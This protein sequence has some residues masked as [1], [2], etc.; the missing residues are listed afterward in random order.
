MSLDDILNIDNFDK[1]VVKLSSFDWGVCRYVYDNI[2]DFN[3]KADRKYDR[4]KDKTP[5]G[6]YVF[7]LKRVCAFFDRFRSPVTKLYIAELL[8][9]KDIEGFD[10]EEC[11]S[12]LRE[13]YDNLNKN[14]LYENYNPEWEANNRKRLLYF[15][16]QFGKNYTE[17]DIWGVPDFIKEKYDNMHTLYL[18]G[19]K[20]IRK[21]L[22]FYGSRVPI[23][24]ISYLLKIDE[25]KDFDVKECN[26]VLE[27]IALNI[28]RMWKWLYRSEDE[29]KRKEADEWF[30]KIW[31]F[32]SGKEWELER[33]IRRI[34]E[35]EDLKKM[36]AK[37]RRL[38]E[39]KYLESLAMDF[40]LFF[41]NKPEVVPDI[42]KLNYCPHC[43]SALDPVDIN[44]YAI[45]GEKS[46]SMDLRSLSKVS[47]K[48]SIMPYCSRCEKIYLEKEDYEE[49]E[50]K[51]VLFDIS[52]IFG[53]FS[54]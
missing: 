27:E 14:L 23:G 35:P 54:C 2:Y 50:K 40:A 7:F 34:Y 45:L 13:L 6:E 28:E 22:Y 10:V 25:L 16:N 19:L 24:T 38:K 31:R 49:L 21:D 30:K 52:V 47:L 48:N 41:K 43:Y 3:P 8:N 37:E 18:D 5:K 46:F 33:V 53:M 1:L 39:L 12:Y 4:I 42:N 36:I 20:D 29:S 15:L 11:N 44:K 51:G 9:Y 17:E 32:L 26:A